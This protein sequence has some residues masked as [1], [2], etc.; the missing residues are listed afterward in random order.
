M[1]TILLGM[2]KFDVVIKDL[3]RII[4]TSRNLDDSDKV[5]MK[6]AIRKY[7]AVCTSNNQTDK[8]FSLDDNR[9]SCH[10]CLQQ[11]IDEDEAQRLALANTLEADNATV[12]QRQEFDA[13]ITLRRL[14]DRTDT[15]LFENQELE[16]QRN[17]Q[18][19]AQIQEED[20]SVSD[21]DS[22][23]DEDEDEEIS[24]H[25]SIDSMAEQDN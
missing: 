7:N 2:K 6:E 4:M 25:P 5:W 21:T 16:H 18:R 24:S 12:N 14:S 20:C 8:V 23:I 11:R 15:I 19:A 9:Q 22:N 3:L 13:F 10:V 17:L 1:L